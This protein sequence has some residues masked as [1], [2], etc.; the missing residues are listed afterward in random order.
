MSSVDYEIK[1]M[2]KSPFVKAL[3]LAV[4]RNIL[5]HKISYDEKHVIDTSLVPGVSRRVALASLKERKFEKPEKELTMPV[6]VVPQVP[7]LV[8]RQSLPAPRV[9]PFHMAPPMGAGAAGVQGNY[10]KIT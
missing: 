9:M 5:S 3:A 10:G 7:Q 1:V 2:S 4:I 8:R 6:P